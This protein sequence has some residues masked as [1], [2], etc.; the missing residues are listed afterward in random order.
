MRKLISVKF[1][2]A[3]IIL[4][5]IGSVFVTAAPEKNDMSDSLFEVAALGII[6]GD[7]DGDFKLE[8]KV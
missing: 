5:M 3:L 6:K 8:E 2:S 1:I 7:D 4:S